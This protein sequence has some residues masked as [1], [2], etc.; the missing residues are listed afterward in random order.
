MAL[1][2][3]GW[4]VRLCLLSC[5]GAAFPTVSAA[6]SESE[7]AACANVAAETEPGLAADC[8]TLLGLRDE[9]R[10]GAE[11]NWSAE[12]PIAEWSGLELGGEPRRVVGLELVRRGLDGAI[13]AALGELDGLRRLRLSD[14]RLGGGIPPELGRL[15]R[16]ILLA[17]DD[18][19]LTGAPPPALGGLARL[20]SLDLSGNRLA[21]ALPGAWAE[22]W[23]LRRL[24]LLDNRLAGTAPLWLADFGLESLELSGNAGLEGCL[25][26]E[27]SAVD[28]HDLERLGLDWCAPRP[29][30][31]LRL[32]EGAHGII[33]PVAGRHLYPEG[34]RVRLRAL[35]RTGYRVASWSGTEDR[36][37]GRTPVCVVRIDVDR[38]V[39]V[40]FEQITYSLTVSANEGGTVTPTG[41]TNYTEP[42]T[43]TLQASWNDATH[44]F[45]GWSGD[46]VGTTSSCEVLVDDD[47][48]VTATFA[49][50]PADRCSTPTAS[51]CIR[52]V[53]RGAPD[54]YRQVADIPDTALI[55]RGADGRYT[56]ERGE[57]V[58]VVTAAPLPSG[59][60]RFVANIRPD[61]E[62]RPTAHLQLVPSLGTTFSLTASGDAYAADRFELDLHAARNRRGGGK[63]IP[64]DVVVTA[65]FSVRP[66]PLM[67]ELTSSRELCTAG[68][69]TELSWT[70]TG[71][72]PPY[73]LTIDGQAV[74]AEAESHRVNCG[75]IPTD[76][77]TGDPAD[78][79]I[80][81]FTATVTDSQT[82]PA[83]AVAR[84]SVALAPP[85]APPSGVWYDTFVD[86]LGIYWPE[87][88]AAGRAIAAAGREAGAVARYKP[89]NSEVWTYSPYY[90][91]PIMWLETEPGEQILQLTAVRTSIEL[92][93]PEAL[94]WSAELRLA[95]PTAATGVVT[96][97]T[98][99]S[100]TVTWDRQALSRIAGVVRLRSPEHHYLVR[101][102]RDDGRTGR[103]EVVFPH[104][105]PNTDYEIAIVH[106]HG[107]YGAI[108]SRH[109]IRTKPA[110]SGWQAPARGPQNLRASASGAS[111]TISW[112]HPFTGA[113]PNYLVQVYENSTGTRIDS[114][115]F[116]DG[117]TT[118]TTRG[119]Y[120]W[121]VHGR[122]YRIRILHDA[123]PQAE[124]T[125]TVTVPLREAARGQREAPMP[126]IPGLEAFSVPFRP[127]WPIAI[128]ED[129]DYVD[130][131]YKWRLTYRR[132]PSLNTMEKCAAYK[133]SHPLAYWGP[134]NGQAAFCY[135][136]IPDEARYHAGLDIGA[137]D[138][139]EEYRRAGAIRGDPVVASE[140][141]WLRLYNHVLDEANGVYFCPQV[142]GL[143]IDQFITSNDPR[144]TTHDCNNYLV[145]GSSG[146]TI[147]IFHDRGPG[148]RY[149]TKYAHLLAGSI[150]ATLLT[151]LGVASNCG[152]DRQTTGAGGANA[153]C[154][155]DADRQVHVT[156]DAAIGAVG[157]SQYLKSRGA[158][159]KAFADVHLHFEIRRF[160]GTAHSEWYKAGNAMGCSQLP[161]SPCGWTENREMHTVEDVEDHLPPLPASW[162]PTD[163]GGHSSG[164]WKPSEP[165]IRRVAANRR[166]I[167]VAAGQFVAGDSN[168][169]DTLRVRLSVAIWRPL[170]YS[171]YYL[172]P[173]RTRTHGIAGTRSGVDR[174]FVASSCA[175][176]TPSPVLG[177]VT[178][179]PATDAEGNAT[180]AGELP[181]Q[182][183]VVDL[184]LDDSCTLDVLTGNRSYPLPRRESAS[185][186]WTVP[187]DDISLQDP[188]AKVRWAA[189]LGIA[190]NEL[191]ALRTMFGN[192]LDLFTFK[193]IPG[194]T[195][196]FC[197]VTATAELPSASDCQDE[198]SASSVA[199]IL[200]VG[201]AEAGQSGVVTSGLTRGANGLSWTVP[202][203]PATVETYAVVVRRRARYE[204]GDVAAHSYRLKYTIPK[205]PR[206]DNDA[207]EPLFCRPQTPVVLRTSSVMH[208]SAMVHF[209]PGP[210]ATN[211]R[212][213]RIGGGTRVVEE[214]LGGKDARTHTLSRLSADTEYTIRVQ[215]YNSAAESAWSGSRMV[216]TLGLPF[217]SALGGEARDGSS[218]RSAASCRLG[219]PVGLSVGDV[220]AASARVSWSSGDPQTSGYGLS[221]D[222]RPLDPQPDLRGA[223]S[224]T[225]AGLSTATTE[226]V[227]GVIATGT[228][229]A[230]SEP[231]N[232]TLLLPPRLTAPTATQ[233]TLRTTW[234]TDPR[235]TGYQVKLGA[236]GT[237][238]L[239]E[240]D[241]GHTFR[242]L[243]SDTAFELYVRARNAQGESA[244]RSVR[245][246]TNP[247]VGC[248]PVEQ[249]PAR[250]TASESETVSI[251]TD[252][253]V[254]DT[255]AD[256]I[257]TTI[258]RTRTR[259]VSWLA[260]PECRWQT[261]EW[262]EWVSSTTATTLRTLPRPA[263]RTRV[264]E[265]ENG[266]PYWTVSGGTACEW[267]DWMLQPQRNQAVFSEDAE[268]WAFHESGWADDGPPTT[269]ARRTETPCIRRPADRTRV[270]ED[271]SGASY[272]IVSGGTACEWQRWT[273][274]PQRNQAEFSA[275]D[276]AWQFHESGWADDGAPTADARRTRTP[277]K[278]RPHHYIDIVPIE[279]TTETR[280]ERR[281]V[282]V[283]LEYEQERI[284]HRQ[285]HYL[286][287]Y[288]W[289]AA[290]TEWQVGPRN[291]ST[292]VFTH[293]PG[294][295]SF[296]A[297]K[298]TG[299][300]RLCP[301]QRRS[302]GAVSADLPAG[303]YIMQWGEVRF[304]FTVPAGASVTL[305]SR[306]E[307][308]GVEAAVFSVESGAE[309]VVDPS[310][311]STDA[312]ANASLFL[313][314]TDTTLSQL[315]ATLQRAQTSAASVAEASSGCVAAVRPDEG[316]AG[317]NLG[318]R[319]CALVP[320]GGALVVSKDD[321]SLSLTLPA[322]RDWMLV[323]NTMS[324]GALALTLVDLA[325]GGFLT[326][327][328][329]DARELARQ[330][331]EGNT[332]LASLFTAIL[333]GASA[334]GSG[335]GEAQ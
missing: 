120:W 45:T 51:D 56:I 240:S 75:P 4:L 114:K 310:T 333:A 261:G 229:V 211:Y 58:T 287:P 315:G 91:S 233:N 191:S 154:K 79:P 184:G 307:K 208:D 195:Y 118:W 278:D 276:E 326:L 253:V 153:E 163:P 111:I 218:T 275:A 125:I 204:G 254:G 209:A 214:I 237:I 173:P 311:L 291:P 192:A 196:R 306:V 212:I 290:A 272:W 28:Y 82:T 37:A 107:D 265:D 102:F 41:T 108:G 13:P 219:P 116:N 188:S 5:L 249:R 115:Y 260:A 106:G 21:G 166:V 93:T 147:L 294:V 14:N 88:S 121:V 255:K 298:N 243:A 15:E 72:K 309:L 323:R 259:T 242:G 313:G 181:R 74:D 34:A 94:V 318:E 231:A 180:P 8:E 186:R 329:A 1:I 126:Q 324:D 137:D 141:G 177:P 256:E 128:D 143:F 66:A 302:E 320:G 150:P 112:E 220:T 99:D 119:R 139:N 252:W 203:T 199:E 335:T 146:R 304:A 331:P 264:N 33:S 205:P 26:D 156:K 87:D 144:R 270:D 322:G 292:P 285:S 299:T 162:A 210:G 172:Q 319:T 213:E 169:P 274:Q 268:A 305:T 81:T 334:V 80:K 232:L 247:Q 32:A 67:L 73:T 92:E 327:S 85:L 250:P 47:L 277:C 31:S 89:A 227:F 289:N 46:C 62:P 269:E 43:V 63:P 53:Y 228:G 151:E 279:E 2:R 246:R 76:P 201:P 22:L 271:E 27:L 134:D 281:E 96:S 25:P 207:Q 152:A 165:L 129:Y 100:I 273:L 258:G 17:L 251:S 109:S 6:P 230:D 57:Q 10:G 178:G 42:T 71:G 60:D 130:D 11:L 23:S 122:T 145:G 225:F 257:R 198:S 29:L 262:Q 127:I 149:V 133:V 284:G 234:T 167:E 170:F 49:A 297:W 312:A 78:N 286:R 206:C 174:Y 103:H 187:R 7:S 222:G 160:D 175:D 236:A 190:A 280:W 223:T 263:D 36:C 24:A 83:N 283:C 267:Q 303:D 12:R 288:V 179:D 131:P 113:E 35:P 104:L 183:I 55:P 157:N 308:S 101:S 132:E 217:C 84:P 241:S 238:G 98:H 221:L 65:Q 239:A 20:E 189:S 16:L 44:S 77:I 110:P 282:I 316:G 90:R 235:A 18:N 245:G 142:G 148:Q 317:I 164:E 314:V 295:Y 168:T 52:A 59:Q 332:E 54:D 50:L 248:P 155:A 330:S 138:E 325:S 296:G 193:A 224:H 161:P 182:N 266:D 97:A 158:L 64:G 200:I 159:E 69:L 171:R 301:L 321:R 202:T 194:L 61:A 136:D 244:W 117:T 123:I 40:W 293:P 105:S 176:E 3:L 215:G 300:T 135:V 124:A 197:T 70:I 39:A 140:S 48:A 226:H 68:T 9:L 30:R 95:R 38:S 86:R 216:R 19:E 185:G 328:F